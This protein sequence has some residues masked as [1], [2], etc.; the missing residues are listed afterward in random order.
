MKTIL[1]TI[2]LIGGLTLSAAAD[3]TVTLSDTHICCHSCVNAINKI[4]ASVDGL[5]ATPSQED[6]T[7]TLSAA[8]KATLQKG[9]DALTSAGFYGKSSDPDV[10]VNG[11]TGAKNQTVQTITVENLHLCCP[12][13]VKA[14]N[15]ILATVPGVTT[16]TATKGAKEF[17]VTGNFNDK[18]VFDAFQAH[19]LTG[20]E[21]Q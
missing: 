18:A 13:C 5:K 10:K 21:K 16:N 4:G 15:E 3:Q 19:G 20:Q 1:A 17:T 11:D 6:G 7:I 2:G 14:V 8:D 12:K 9:V